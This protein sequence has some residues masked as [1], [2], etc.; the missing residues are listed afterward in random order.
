MTNA[1]RILFAILLIAVLA[2]VAFVGELTGQWQ[3]GRDDLAPLALVPGGPEV[4]LEGRIWIDTDAACGATRSDPDDCLAI[5][6]L[7]H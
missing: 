4:A 7:S 1:Q 5:L 2:V 3:T 6:W